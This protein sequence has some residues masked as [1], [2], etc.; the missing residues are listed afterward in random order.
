MDNLSTLFT[1][2]ELREAL[3]SL[4]EN[5]DLV[6]SQ[7]LERIEQQ[8]KRQRQLAEEVLMWVACTERQL[9][10]KELQLALASA[11]GRSKLEDY[12]YP[13]VQLT[14]VCAGL[15]IIEQKSHLVR[16][17]RKCLGL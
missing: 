3:E 5:V 4:S 15:V 13:A 16:F 17:V 9:S 12:M 10:V 2:G 6:Y 14:S 11:P 1:V 8:G 7:A